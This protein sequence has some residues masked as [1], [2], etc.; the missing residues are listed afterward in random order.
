VADELARKVDA[1]H[2]RLDDHEKDCE[3]RLGRVEMT[4]EIVL[5]EIKARLDDLKGLPEEV[6]ALRAELSARRK[7]GGGDWTRWTLAALGWLF[8][9]IALI[10]GHLLR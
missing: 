3:R 2:R 7:N 6:A 5:A 8:A 4:L 1:L 10:L 9:L